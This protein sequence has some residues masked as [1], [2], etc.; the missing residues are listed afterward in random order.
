[1]KAAARILN[2]RVDAVDSN[3]IIPMKWPE[4]EF[5]TA[6]SFRK[7]CQKNLLDALQTIPAKNPMTDI[8]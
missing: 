3:G 6:Y 4:K 1:M 7:I 5:T 8:K 2:V